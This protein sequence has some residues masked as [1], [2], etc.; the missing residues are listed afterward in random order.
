LFVVLFSS[1]IL[2]RTT[3]GSP[4]PT[5]PLAQQQSPEVTEQQLPDLVPWQQPLILPQLPPLA[6]QPP[7]LLEGSYLFTYR[8]S[9]HVKYS[10]PDAFHNAARAVRELLAEHQ[11][12]I[13]PD[14]VRG[15][16]ETSE[17]FSTE[18]MLDLARRT[19]A[20]YLLQVA[21]DRPITKWLKVSIQCYDMN[22]KL[23]WQ[24]EASDGG[25]F[26]SSGSLR[27]VTSEL[28]RRLEQRLGGPGLL[29]TMPEKPPAAGANPGNN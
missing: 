15:N 25:G 5:A 24:E 8:T 23:L 11:I 4:Q 20:T 9:G 14:P 22:G 10:D 17:S 21:I 19:G 12:A 2:A 3:A 28:H 27:K 18:S 7:R 26:N 6:V 16:T 1:L 13:F 29:T